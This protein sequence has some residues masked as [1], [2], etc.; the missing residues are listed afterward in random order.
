M[1]IQLQYLFQIVSIE[2]LFSSTTHV[3]FRTLKGLVG[4]FCKKKSHKTTIKLAHLAERKLEI[5][6]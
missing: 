4:V 1:E 6:V 3:N 2:T 5:S